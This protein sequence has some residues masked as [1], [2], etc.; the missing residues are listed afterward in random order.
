MER[1]II[2][3]LL[4]LIPLAAPAQE[5]FSLKECLDYAVEHNEKLRKDELSMQAAELSRK[6]IL[7]AL[8]PQVNASGTMTRNIQ[9]TTIAMPNFMNSMLP[10][11]MQDP[12]APKYM[13]VTMGMDYTANWGFGLSQQIVNFPLFNALG[14]AKLAGEMS[15]IGS[16]LNTA[17]V[18]AQTAG[19]YYAVQVLTYAVGR[20]DESIALMDKTLDMLAINRESGL[21]RPVDVKQVQVTRT[22]LETE[23]QSMIQAIGIQKNLIKLQMGYPMER[24]IEF[25]PIDLEKME[26][27]VYGGGRDAFELDSQLPFRLF[28]KQ[29]SMT[30]L[31][32]KSAVSEVLPVLSLSANYSMAY[33]GDAFKGDTYH[34]FPVSMVSLNLRVPIF[35][36]LSKTAK[37]K[38][39]RLEVQKA[40]CDERSIESALSMAYGNALMSLE[41]S[42][43]TM[44]SQKRNREM[45]KEVFA[46]MESNYR[47]GI[48]S[49]SDLLNANSALIRSEMNYVNALS[50]CMKAYIDLKK[51]DGTI[52]EI[53]K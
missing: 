6:E 31:Q 9:K 1:R 12:N 43:K 38:K 41:Q 47:E 39:A 50:S 49:L 22:N 28:K 52:E 46:V 3:L 15:E 42:R 29:Q 32:Y 2:A 10:P 14:I 37:I 30:G 21:M 26:S 48:S 36:G 51:A 24:E 18:L 19:L 8:L 16:R 4:W 20:F 27:E 13:T 5:M 11:A 23:K 44:D 53:K 34:H 25:A 40:L 35:T 33:M 7:G 45:A 17:D